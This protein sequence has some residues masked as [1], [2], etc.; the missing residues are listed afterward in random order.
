MTSWAI[1]HQAPLS[2]GLLRQEHI[3]FSRE[4]PDPGYEPMSPALADGI[5]TISATCE[6]LS[7][8]S[9][10]FSLS[11]MSNSGTPWTG[12]CQASLSIISSRTL[13]KLTSMESVMPSNHLS[14]PLLSPSPPTFNLYQHQSFFQMSQFFTSGGQSI[15]FS[16]S[17]SVL[18][19]NTQD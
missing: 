17:T 5:F 18:P 14:H 8:D 12:E 1:A 4:L 13:L 9:I 7:K 19:M 2:R 16:A 10:Q 15:R 11:V 6:A 3:P